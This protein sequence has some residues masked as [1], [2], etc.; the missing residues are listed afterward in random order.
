VLA[1]LILGSS[2]IGLFAQEGPRLLGISVFALF[3]FLAS[4]FF[5]L[6]LVV[7]ILRS[8]RL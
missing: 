2:I 7:G 4:G 1:S 5:G 6:W 8:G 3:G